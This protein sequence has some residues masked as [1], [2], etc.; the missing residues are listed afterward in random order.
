VKRDF[1]RITNAEGKI[2]LMPARNMRVAMELYQPSGRNGKWMKRLFPWLHRLPMVRKRI[3]AERV[4]VPLPEELGGLL[5]QLWGSAPFEYSLFL[6][7]PGPNQKTTM[8]VFRETQILGYVKWTDSPGIA[9]SF[10]AETQTL[11]YLNAVGVKHIPMALYCGKADGKY[12]FVQS[13]T[14]S[15]HSSVPSAFSAKHV[16]FVEELN[17]KTMRKMPLE[18]A[19]LYGDL[20]YL[21]TLLDSLS[22]SVQRAFEE[23]IPLVENYYRIRPTFCFMHGDFTPWNMYEDKGMLYPFDFEFAA[24]GYPPYM[25]LVHYFLQVCILAENKTLD[26]TFATLETQKRLIPVKEVDYLILAYLLHIFAQYMR[27]FH[28]HFSSN[29]NS[30]IIWTGLTGKYLELCQRRKS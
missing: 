26:G 25:D 6:G 10:E 22:P 12:A 24:M 3:G 8:Q 11:R 14:K 5:H 17:R 30:F 23:A 28:G 7:S 27:L 15:L 18:D 21:R 9:A 29:D 20:Q 2:W 4:T 1:Y 13:T 16:A 19:A